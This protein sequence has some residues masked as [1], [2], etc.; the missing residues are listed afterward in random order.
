VGAQSH[1]ICL[2]LV[3][4]CAGWDSG[5]QHRPAMCRVDLVGGHDASVLVDV[6]GPNSPHRGELAVGPVTEPVAISLTLQLA[7][8]ID[9]AAE[10]RVMGALG[11]LDGSLALPA[12]QADPFVGGLGHVW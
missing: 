3:V 4:M 10:D 12:L 5:S 11:R 6:L 9:S 2:S 7:E 1:G 8:V